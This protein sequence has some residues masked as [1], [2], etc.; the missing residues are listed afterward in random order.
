MQDA[1]PLARGLGK[2]LLH[3]DRTDITTHQHE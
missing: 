3:T 1:D 2:Q